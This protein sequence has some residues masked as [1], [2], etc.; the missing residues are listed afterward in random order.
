VTLTSSNAYRDNQLFYQEDPYGRRTYFAYRAAD[1]ALIRRVQGTVPGFEAEVG[2]GGSSGG[3]G[4]G[5]PTPWQSGT[6]YA[7]GN[8][9]THYMGAEYECIASHLSGSD[10]EPA[11]GYNWQMY[12]TES[13]G[14]GGP[15]GWQSGTFYNVSDVVTQNG[16]TQ[17]ECSSSHTSDIYSEPGVGPYWNMFWTQLAGGGGGG[18]G[19]SGGGINSFVDVL[20]LT[21]GVDPEPNGQLIITDYVLDDAGNT[22]ETID[23]RGISHTSAYDSRWLNKCKR[24]V[25]RWP[26]RRKR[27]TTPTVT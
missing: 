12:W 23:G 15:A 2:G 26:P 22:I 1:G 18:G 11:F 4:G 27:F 24:P 19:G 21:R 6:M 25:R 3:G 16:D 13:T 8:L 17:Y 14:G 20:A 10:S 9:V 7:V 5:G